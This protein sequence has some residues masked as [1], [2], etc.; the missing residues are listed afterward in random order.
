MSVQ[1]PPID[2]TPRKAGLLSCA[3]RSTSL[4]YDVAQRNSDATVR[5]D[6]DATPPLHR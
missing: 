5:S 4:L 3:A 6:A 2:L 1:R